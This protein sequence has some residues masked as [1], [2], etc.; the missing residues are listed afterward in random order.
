MRAELSG[1]SLSAISNQF[2]QA[3]DL[4]IHTVSLLERSYSLMREPSEEVDP[5]KVARSFVP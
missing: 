1:L 4:G 3:K 2:D 5:S